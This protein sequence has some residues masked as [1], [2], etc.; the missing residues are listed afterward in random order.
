MRD[1]LAETREEMTFFRGWVPL[2]PS[3]NMAYKVIT[4]MVKLLTGGRVKRH[5]LGPTPELEQFKRD[6]ACTLKQSYVDWRMVE[7]IRE[8]TRAKVPVEVFLWVYF[9]TPWKRDLDGVL[10]FAIDAVFSYL[11]LNDNLV[12]HVESFKL[13]DRTCPRVELEV[14]PYT[15]SSQEKRVSFL[16]SLPSFSS[17][18]SNPPGNVSPA[19]MSS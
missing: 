19:R 8:A 18:L 10:K 1:V 13:V 3:V 11:G 14:C 15:L 9:E 12:V 6:A 5:S 16:S 4:V 17:S 7:Q 2:P